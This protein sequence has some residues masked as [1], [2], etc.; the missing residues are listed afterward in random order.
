MAACP[1]DHLTEQIVIDGKSTDIVSLEGIP[2]GPTW[3]AKYLIGADEN[4]RD[5]AVRLLYGAGSPRAISA[6]AP[7]RSSVACWT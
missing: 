4:G 5:L 7:T 6:G 1:P 2:I 3:H